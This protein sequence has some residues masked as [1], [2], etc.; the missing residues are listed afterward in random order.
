DIQAKV[1]DFLPGF[2]DTEADVIKGKDTMRIIDVLHHT[3]GF[4]PDPQYH[5]P[6]VS[7]ELYSQEREKTIENIN[8]TPLTY[9][10]GTKNV[11]SDV[12]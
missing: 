2:K 12:D 6:A 4:K 3:A 7:G 8:K 10:P 11:Y 9:E 5:N 1:Q